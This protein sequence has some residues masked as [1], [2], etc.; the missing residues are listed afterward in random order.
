MFFANQAR[1]TPCVIAELE[2]QS[3]KHVL[4]DTAISNP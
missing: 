3:F 2:A 4:W 1:L